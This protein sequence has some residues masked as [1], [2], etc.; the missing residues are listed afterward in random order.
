MDSP[1]FY[2]IYGPPTK[3]RESNVFTGVCH[4]VRGQGVGMPDPRSLLGVYRRGG[5]GI[6]QGWDR[7]NQGVAV[8]GDGYTWYTSPSVLTSSDIH[9]S[10]RYASCWNAFLLIPVIT[11]EKTQSQCPLEVFVK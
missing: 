8:P 11:I 10:G 5:V 3:L 2:D 9:R 7:Y 1:I 6:P 4:S